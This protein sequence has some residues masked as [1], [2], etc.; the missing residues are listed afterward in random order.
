M[1]LECEYN[2]ASVQ[3]DQ[4]F[5]FSHT[6]LHFCHQAFFCS[7]LIQLIYL[8]KPHNVSSLM[9]VSVIL[10]RMCSA[11]LTRIIYTFVQQDEYSN[12]SDWRHDGVDDC[13]VVLLKFWDFCFDFGKKKNSI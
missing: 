4:S 7:A 1:E 5:C 10:D 11:T 3:I 8:F 2:T 6:A 12:F 13:S 9:F